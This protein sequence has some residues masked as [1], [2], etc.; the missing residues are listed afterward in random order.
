M[1]PCAGRRRR[2]CCGGRC[3][4]L[5]P[6]GRRRLILGSAFLW[7]DTGGAYAQKGGGFKA[8]I[9]QNGIRL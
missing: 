6:A 3:E 1:W 5:F 9:Q 2:I 7:E 4:V 8:H